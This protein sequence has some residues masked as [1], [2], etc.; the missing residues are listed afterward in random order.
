MKLINKFTIMS[1]LAV[2][3]LVSCKDDE[4][5]D[6]GNP[7]MVYDGLP[8]QVFFGDSLPF[9]VKASDDRVPLSTVKGELYLDGELIA[10]KTVRTKVSGEYYEGRVFI[11]YL[12]YASGTKG[13]LHLTLQNINFTTTE[14]EVEF[15]VDYPD[16]PSLTLLAEDGTSYTMRRKAYQQYEAVENFPQAIAGTIIAPAY[17]ENG[18]ELRFGFSGD[19]IEA[20][21]KSLINFR[22]VMAGQYAV[23]FNTFTYEYGPL[24]ILRFGENEFTQVDGS[25]Y[26]GDFYLNSF[27]D[28]E[29]EGLPD[30]SDWWIDPDFF[31]I[32][33]GKLFFNAYQGYYRVGINLENKRLTCTKIDSMGQLEGLQADGSGTIW[34]MGTGIGKPSYIDNQIGWIPANKIPFAPIGDKKF[35]LTLTTGQTLCYNKFTLRIFNDPP[36]GWG[37]TFTPARLTLNTDLLMMG[38][39]GK[40][41]HNIYLNTGKVLDENATYEMVVDLSAGNDAAVLTLTKIS[42]N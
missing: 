32:R 6:P 3:M 27:Q 29:A 23:T 31:S 25:N 21:G 36:A 7:V 38:V 30:L 18:N 28:L 19:A 37:P 35:R 15:T 24:G 9:R 22:N 12:P 2:G 4:A 13:K 42:N 5:K 8:A 10:T 14:Q 1:L 26:T 39:P 16:F 11:P 17:G 34:M 20:G 40:E 33:S 41:A